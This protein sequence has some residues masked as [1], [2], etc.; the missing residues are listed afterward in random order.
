MPFEAALSEVL[1]VGAELLSVAVH[2]PNFTTP[3]SAIPSALADALG[4]SIRRIEQTEVC[5]LGRYPS[6]K[7]VR[8][9]GINR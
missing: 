9:V 7:K 2:V 5:A 8:N 4:C 6:E 3:N 1:H